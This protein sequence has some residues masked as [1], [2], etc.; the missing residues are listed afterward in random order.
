M[1]QDFSTKFLFN[2]NTVVEI[3]S[4]YVDSVMVEVSLVTDNTDLDHRTFQLEADEVDLFIATLQ[5]YK[6]RIL[7]GKNKGGLRNDE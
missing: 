7:E 4:D 3:S 1:S 5:L 6:K 2:Q